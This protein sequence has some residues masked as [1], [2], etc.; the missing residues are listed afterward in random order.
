M[1]T[2]LGISV[3]THGEQH[4]QSCV[5]IEQ[6]GKQIR[7]SFGYFFNADIVYGKLRF[8]NFVTVCYNDISGI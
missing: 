6:S 3:R 8:G 4:L 1:K 2:I 5:K 7:K